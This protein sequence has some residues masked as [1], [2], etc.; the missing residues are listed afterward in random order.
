MVDVGLRHKRPA[1]IA[2]GSNAT[3]H[4]INAISI[5]CW[6]EY[7]TEVSVDRLSLLEM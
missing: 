5:E 6:G 7:V 1:L 3:K 4:H 2:A